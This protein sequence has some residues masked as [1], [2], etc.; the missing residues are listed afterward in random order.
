MMRKNVSFFSLDLSFNKLNKTLLKCWIKN[1]HLLKITI[2]LLK[3]I[4]KI[5][6]LY[7]N[8]PIK[9]EN[10]NEWNKFDC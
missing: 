6:K 5:D 8:Y 9:K 10:F 4:Q 3:H 1:F 7:K 2:K